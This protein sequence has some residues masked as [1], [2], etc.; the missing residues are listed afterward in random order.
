MKIDE[1]PPLSF[2]PEPAAD[3]EDPR[4][5]VLTE[6]VEHPDFDSSHSPP[7]ALEHWFWT[8][9][10]PH[11][12]ILAPGLMLDDAYFTTRVGLRTSQP[13]LKGDRI[14]TIPRHCIVSD[15][16]AVKVLRARG[17]GSPS[18]ENVVATL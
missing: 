11:G 18:E 9:C 4:T 5:R 10:L 7:N 1:K 6:A 8:H 17:L 12:G 2:T 13:I 16:D 3:L 15:E 14:M